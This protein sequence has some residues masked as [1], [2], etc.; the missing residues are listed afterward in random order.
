MALMFSDTTNKQGLIQECEFSVFGDNGYGRISGD[1]NLLATFTRLINERLNIVA[2]LI[3]QADGRWQW[4]DNNNTDY[5]IAVTSL[6]VTVG[7]EQQDYTFPV[8]FLKIL[9]VEVLDN[10]GNW[11]KL[12]PIDQ[13]NIYDQSLTDFLKTAGHPIYYDA[14]GNSIFLYP[15]PLGTAVT[16]VGGLKVYFQRPP[17]Y[18]VTIDTTKVPGINSLHHKLIALGASLDYARTNSLP[19]AGG[20]MRGGFKTGLLA[21]VSDGEQRL[22][23]EYALR[24]KDDHVRISAKQYNF[25]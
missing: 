6:G 18:F 22:Q 8:T 17:S 11:N 7:G 12:M 10:A 15:K 24:E 9:R 3:M 16:A 25:R 2:H 4:D 14:Q 23:D 21:E 20:V 5:P 13:A 1:A 19:V